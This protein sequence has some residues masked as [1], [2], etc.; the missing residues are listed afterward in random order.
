MGTL[1]YVILLDLNPPIS[2]VCAIK[3]LDLDAF[4]SSL[5]IAPTRTKALIPIVGNISSDTSCWEYYT[6]FLESVGAKKLNKI[7]G[8]EEHVKKILTRIAKS[9]NTENLRGSATCLHPPETS[10]RKFHNNREI[11]MFGLKTLSTSLNPMYTQVHS[12]T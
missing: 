8:G 4:T 10:G 12:H 2:K 11:T 3:L 5:V 7:F 6:I 9:H 1:H